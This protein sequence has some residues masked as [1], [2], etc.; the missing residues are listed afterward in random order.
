MGLSQCIYFVLGK[1]NEIDKTVVQEKKIKLGAKVVDGSAPLAD[2]DAEAI[3]TRIPRNNRG[4]TYQYVRLIS[5]RQSV[6]FI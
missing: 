3:M 6:Q 4:T 2:V 5:E 1:W